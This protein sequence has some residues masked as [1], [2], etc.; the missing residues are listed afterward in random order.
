MNAQELRVR[1]GRMEAMM[2]IMAK[3]YAEELID[4]T[5][6]ARLSLIE[7][8][9]DEYETK[10]CAVIKELTVKENEAMA[11]AQAGAQ[12]GPEIMQ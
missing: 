8:Y 4:P 3:K 11:K 10:L 2:V 9:L 5:D 6:T 12:A 1:A 7:G